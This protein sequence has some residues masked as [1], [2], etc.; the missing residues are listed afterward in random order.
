MPSVHR[1]HNIS[2]Q[3]VSLHSSEGAFCHAQAFTAYLAGTKEGARPQGSVRFFLVGPITDD[4][5]TMQAR[6]PGRHALTMLPRLSCDQQ[7]SISSR[8][9]AVVLSCS[10]CHMV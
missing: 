1:M 8:H 6:L 2:S 4:L 10:R 3:S 9:E 5:G 7:P